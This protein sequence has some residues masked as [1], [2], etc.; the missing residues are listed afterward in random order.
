M[1]LPE[2]QRRR[3]LIRLIAASGA[4]GAAGMSGFIAR[5]LAKGDLGAVQGINRLEGTVMVGGKPGRIGTPVP[6]GE[7]VA[8]GADSMAVVVV[9]EDA[10]LLRAN[11]IMQPRGSRG[12]L[13]DLLISSGRVLSVFSKKPVQIKAAHATI[14]IRGT[15]AYIEVDP[16]SVYFCLCYGE[17]VVQGAGMADKLVKTT[18]HEQPLLLQQSGGSMRAEPGPFRN[19]SDEELILLESLVGREPPF[20]NDGKYPANKY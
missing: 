11:T 15:G 1:T 17:A 5:A 9:G 7:R 3:A 20:K 19:H 8:T 10:F 2:L 13:S 4:L 12:V 16:G 6:L 14:G 18:H